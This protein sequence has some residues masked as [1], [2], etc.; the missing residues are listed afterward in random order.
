MTILFITTDL[1][2]G[3]AEKQLARLLGRLHRADIVA[4]LVSLL[5]P[6]SVSHEIAALGIQIWHLGLERPGRLLQRFAHLASIARRF[7]PDI[8]QGWMY[9]GNLAAWWAAKWVPRTRLYFGIRQSLYDLAREKPLTRRMIGWN[10]HLSRAAEGVI[11]NSHTAREQH[12]AFGFAA[13]RSLVIDNGFDTELFQPDANSRASVKAEL[14]IPPKAPVIGLIA[15]WHPLKG[16]EVFLE[17]AARLAKERDDVH[18]VMAGRDVVGDREPFATWTVRPPLAGRLHLLNERHDVARLTASFDIASCSSWGEAFP[19]AIGEAMACGV[20]CVA[21]DVGDVRRI[22]ADTGIV[23][24]AGDAKA[25][26]DAWARLLK[27]DADARYRLG[28]VG[29]QRVVDQFGITAV[30]ARYM[31][32]YNSESTP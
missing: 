12:E 5:G 17:A 25:L 1:H 8:L 11:Y 4:G 18:F 21:T 6:G 30:A 3:G 15:R 14:G 26:S 23:V 9:H 27:M 20:P 19:N 29:R 13:D 31:Q 16:H 22:V 24:P 10:A 28:K 32:L 7:H 2:T